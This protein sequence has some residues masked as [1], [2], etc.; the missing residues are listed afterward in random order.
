MK[1]ALPIIIALLF[2]ARIG[3]SQAAIIVLIFGDKV[4]SENFYFSV[5]GGLNLSSTPGIDPSSIKPGAHFGLVANIK[6][7]DRFFFAPEFLPLARKGSRNLAIPFSGNPT[8]DS[9]NL[10]SGS[11]SR[12]LSYIS[13]P[14]HFRFDYTDKLTFQAGPEISFRTGASNFYQ[15]TFENSNAL[16]YSEN[17]KS[18]TKGWDIGVGIDVG[19]V[20]SKEKGGKAMEIHGRYTIGLLDISKNSRESYRNSVF[21]ISAVFPFMVADPK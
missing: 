10:S 13:V 17:I 1:K 15:N 6:I 14:L 18:D 8:L 5:K 4:A 2:I 11:L 19:Y 21:Q 3:F 16:D 12:R 9:I 20:I 7:S